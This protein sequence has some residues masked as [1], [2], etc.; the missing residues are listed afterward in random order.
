MEKNEMVIIQA[1][2]F[3]Y[4]TN[5]HCQDFL[6]Y[7]LSLFTVITLKIAVELLIRSHDCFTTSCNME[8]IASVLR[9]CQQLANS[10]QNLKLWS[11]LV[12]FLK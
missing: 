12:S 9:K 5:R 8:G 2:I 3:S 1:G 10:L 6:F 7:K 11:L 4:I